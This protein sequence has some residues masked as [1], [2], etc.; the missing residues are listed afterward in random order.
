MLF[1]WSGINALVFCGI[2]FG[3]VFLRKEPR[4]K[5]DV[6][7]LVWGAGWVLWQFVFLF[8]T[9]GAADIG[10]ALGFGAMMVVVPGAITAWLVGMA[11]QSLV[12]AA[13]ILGTSVVLGFMVVFAFDPEFFFPNM[14]WHAGFAAAMAVSRWKPRR[15]SPWLCAECAYDRAGLPS[16][17][18]CP[19]CGT[20]PPESNQ[21]SC[22]TDLARP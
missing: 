14:L 8:L 16:D 20:P 5:W 22:S 4:S 21:T 13:V 11:R 18:V 9:I 17:A 3:F 15:H 10:S 12:A 19:E 7:V 1:L 2:Y 6:G